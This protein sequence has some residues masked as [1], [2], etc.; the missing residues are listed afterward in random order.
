MLLQTKTVLISLIYVNGEV[1]TI[2]P[3]TEIG[4]TA[5]KYGILF[6]SDA[7]QGIGKIESSVDKLKVDLMSFTRSQD[8]RSQ[9][10][11]CPLRP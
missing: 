1:G 10:N 2:N 11:R 3:I 7:T 6:H 8:V 9:R 4:E 5:E